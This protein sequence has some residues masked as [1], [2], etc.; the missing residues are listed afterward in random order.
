M[1]PAGYLSLLSR[2]RTALVEKEE[3][4]IKQTYRN[5]CEI[6][7]ANGTLTLTVP[8]LQGSFHKTA[9][10]ECRIDYTKRWPQVHLRAISAAYRAAPYFDFYYN[11]IEKIITKQPLFLL[12]LNHA[13]LA[14]LVSAM[15]ITVAIQ[16]TDS[17][18]PAR[19]APGDYRYRITPKAAP[20]LPAAPYNQVFPAEQRYAA[21]LSSIDLLFNTGPDAIHYL[22]RHF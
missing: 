4:Y 1:P 5:R 7:T 14:F 20:F 9:I 18:T 16:Y 21:N 6:I 22:N 8:V 15:K 17:F 11:E 13:L 12:D 3:N 19:N 10:K 2:A